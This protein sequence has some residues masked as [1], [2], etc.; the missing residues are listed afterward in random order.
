M[1]YE[2]ITIGIAIISFAISS[3]GT[4]FFVGRWTGTQ[5]YIHKEI[6][7]IHKDLEM[8]QTSINDLRKEAKEDRHKFRG[9]IQKWQEQMVTDIN[10]RFD[11]LDCS[12]KRR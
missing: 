3:G 11:G 12:P 9:D 6:E 5:N 1:D 10:R 2:T 7:S 8:L 4:I